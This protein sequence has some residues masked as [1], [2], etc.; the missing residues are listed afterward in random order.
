MEYAKEL[1]QYE[2]SERYV[3]RFDFDTI[4]KD[5]N[6]DAEADNAV[7][8]LPLHEITYADVRNRAFAMA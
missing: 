2:P 8:T 7:S 5:L 1:A 4:E 3:F 6:L